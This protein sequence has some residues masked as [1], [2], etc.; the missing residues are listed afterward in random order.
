MVPERLRRPINKI[1]QANF[2]LDQLKVELAQDNVRL[3]VVEAYL[4]GLLGAVQSSFYALRKNHR[5]TFDPIYK[6]WRE[7]LLRED[8]AFLN[9]MMSQRDADVHSGGTTLHINITIQPAGQTF[10][11]EFR[12]TLGRERPE[13]VIACQR[14]IALMTR[15]IGQFTNEGG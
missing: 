2:L 10:P 6:A 5:P 11:N 14:F 15:L 13:V 8:R 1:E 3:W 9:V 4:G 7:N 12:L